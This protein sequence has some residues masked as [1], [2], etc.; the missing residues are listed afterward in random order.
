[1]I[2]TDTTSIGFTSDSASLKGKKMLAIVSGCRNSG[3]TWFSITLSQALSLFKQKVLLFDG[4]CGLN[5]IKIQLGLD[6][7]KDLNL[8]MSGLKSLNQ[9]IFDYDRGHFSVAAGNPGASGLSTLAVGRLQILGDDL[10]I[11]SQ[12]YD[13]TILDIRTGLSNSTKV[14]AGMSQSAIVVCTDA[15]QSITDNYGLIKL[16]TTR[17]PKTSLGVVV[18][19][20]NDINSG[21]RTY[22]MLNKACQEFLKISPPLLGVIRQDTRV[23]DSIRNQSTII[24]RYPQS[25]AALDVIAIAKRILNNE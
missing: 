11:L 2:D 5:N 7:A 3:K 14:L 6:M 16:L 12:N 25:E 10:N 13:F 8:V 4:D 24:N 22:N 20:V 19:Q 23:R 18:N 9:V 1:M 21:L 17:Y 15:P